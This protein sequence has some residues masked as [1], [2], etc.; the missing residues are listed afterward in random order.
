MAENVKIQLRT[1]RKDMNFSEFE[2]LH[3]G[4]NY[5][6]LCDLDG[7]WRQRWRERQDYVMAGISMDDV[8]AIDGAGFIASDL[9]VSPDAFALT[10][11]Y[12]LMEQFTKE[13]ILSCVYWTSEDGDCYCYCHFLVFPLKNRQLT[14]EPWIDSH[15]QKILP[16][17]RDQFYFEVSKR[18]G[19]AVDSFISKSNCGHTPYL[20]AFPLVKASKEELYET[21]Y[22]TITE[23]SLVQT[24][25]PKDKIQTLCNATIK[26][27]TTGVEKGAYIKL[28]N[29]EMTPDE[30][31]DEVRLYLKRMYKD[32]SDRDMEIIIRKVKSAATGFYILDELIKDQR[33]SDIK[34]VSPYRIRVKVE[35]RRKT[36]NLRFIDED[37]Y[38][39]FLDGIIM[40]YGLDP[41]INIHKVDAI[42]EDGRFRLRINLTIGEINC[43]YPIIH[44]LKIPTV[45]YTID[46]LV[47]IGVM[48]E[49]VANYLLWAAREAKGLVITG[50]GSAGKSTIINTLLEYPPC[51]A[52]GLVIQES[53]ELFSQRPE[54]TFEHITAEHDLKSLAKNG[55]LTDIDYFIIGEVKGE[56]AMYFINACDTGN[57][58]WCSVHSPSSEEAI[59]KLADYVMY[60][61]K[62]SHKEALYMLKELQVIIFM[63]NFK[64]AEISEVIGWDDEND[65]LKYRTVFRRE[66]LIAVPTG[67]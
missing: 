38:Y 23:E 20:D 43:G 1:V 26:Y 22:D 27:F 53:N 24:D 34:V 50:K 32:M 63:K 2:D 62:Y 8:I 42:D 10:V 28:N 9:I 45:K 59:N 18:L 40:R 60:A 13:N 21:F 3:K 6:E 41:D 16:E 31:L 48:D 39:R 54:M 64:V 33:I 17:V 44:I 4:K 29:G 46:D 14:P 19:L 49:T 55:L 58:A 51:D 5:K 36:S 66:D 7:S 61:S 37:D 65:R 15:T 35:G 12:F 56:E 47:K 11:K 67:E 25:F 52:S 57:K 30:Y